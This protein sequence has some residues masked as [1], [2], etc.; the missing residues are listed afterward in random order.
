MKIEYSK[1]ADILMIELRD[2]SPS[3]SIDLKEGFIRLLDEKR[4]RNH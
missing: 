1:E 4:G 2:R 3:N